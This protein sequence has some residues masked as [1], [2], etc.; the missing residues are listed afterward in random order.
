M[1]YF[2]YKQLYTFGIHCISLF[3][4]FYVSNYTSFCF[5]LFLLIFI[6]LLFPAFSFQTHL[7]FYLIFCLP[8]LIFLPELFPSFFPSVVSFCFTLPLSLL[9]SSSCPLCNIFLYFHTH[10]VFFLLF[11]LLSPFILF[12]FFFHFWGFLLNIYLY[13][14]ISL[15]LI[16]LFCGDLS[17][18]LPTPI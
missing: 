6:F 10:L 16:S 2:P 8:L 15:F 12:F 1:Y 9:G 18:S 3:L 13:F 4:S 7:F 11:L 17:L 14:I 5:L